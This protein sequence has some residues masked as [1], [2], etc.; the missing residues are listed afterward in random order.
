[1]DTGI[2][3]Q[4]AETGRL[5]RLGADVFDPRDVGARRRFDRHHESGGSRN[6]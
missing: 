3:N 4:P 1:M 2:E 6:V 5:L